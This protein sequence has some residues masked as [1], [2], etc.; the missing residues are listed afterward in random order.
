VASGDVLAFIDAEWH[1]AGDWIERAC[2]AA[3]QHDFQCAVSS[4]ATPEVPR[5]GSAAVAYSE[6]IELSR[7]QAG[8]QVSAAA[9]MVVPRPVWQRVGPFDEGLAHPACADWEWATRAAAHGVPIVAATD[10]AVR[11]PVATTWRAL[12][13]NARSSVDEDICLARA[14]KDERFLTARG[15]LAAY[16]RLGVED[17]RTA[18]GDERIPR[19]ARLGACAAAGWR[20]IARIAESSRR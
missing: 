18:Y 3:R 2:A 13:E 6:A 10:A 9:G 8:R 1:G 14:G 5:T 15:R 12:T 17:V 16:T 20:Y 7:R 11:R 4:H 19:G